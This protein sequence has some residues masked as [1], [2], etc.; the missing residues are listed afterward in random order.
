MFVEELRLPPP[1]LYTVE[2]RGLASLF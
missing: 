2:S 1:P